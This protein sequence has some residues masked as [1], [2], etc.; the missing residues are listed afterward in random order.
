MQE[1]QAHHGEQQWSE[2]EWK[3]W[4]AN[5]KGH[6]WWAGSWAWDEWNAWTPEPAPKSPMAMDA[7]T[8]AI[9]NLLKRGHTVD[10]MNSMDLASLAAHIEKLRDEREGQ[11]PQSAKRARNAG[12]VIESSPVKN[13]A[14]GPKPLV[15]EAAPKPGSSGSKP[16]VSQAAPNPG[17]VA[18]AGSKPD[19]SQAAPET[20]SA[21]A[22][23]SK[24]DGEPESKEE[25]KKRLHAR[26][27]RF[28]RSLT[29]SPLSCHIHVYTCYMYA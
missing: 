6:G 16:L 3:A 27:M 4:R 26:F 13:D 1:W 5:W 8:Q 25:R 21:V 11:E 18:A 7:C 10:R 20:G 29:S 23:G 2:E 19:V 28:S 24:P 17:S 15:S 14:A 22:T 12:Q 9:H